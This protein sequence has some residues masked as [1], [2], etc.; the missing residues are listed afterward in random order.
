[1]KTLQTLLF[2]ALC[3][4]AFAVVTCKLDL[5]RD[6]L[7]AEEKQI[8]VVKVSL[9]AEEP[10]DITERAP[11]NLCIVLDRSGSMSGSKLERAKKA[12]VAALRRLNRN[13]RFSLV[14]YDHGVETIVP[15]RSAAD[16]EWIEARIRSI[17]AGGNTAL[18]AGVSQGAAEIRKQLDDKRFTHRILLLSD[19]LANVGPSSPADLG[20]LGKALF[21]EQITVS[22]I[23]LG[24]GYN[25]D[26][27]AELAGKSD[28][29]MYFVESSDD[30]ANIFD[31]ELGDVLRVT[32]RKVT[33]EITIPEGMRPL[34][35]VGRDARI[36]NNKVELEF[37]QLYGGQ[38]K[39]ALMEIE[40]TGGKDGSAALLASAECKY[41]SALT[42]KR[43]QAAGK[44]TA[45][46]S[47]SK[48]EIVKSVDQ[49]VQA[50]YNL[51]KVA[52]LQEK[53]LEL[54][55]EGR[56]EEAVQ[57]LKEESSRLKNDADEYS[58]SMLGVQSERLEEVADKLENEGMS[59][60]LRKSTKNEAYEIK[61]QQSTGSWQETYKLKK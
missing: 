51:N 60:R 55:D 56:E 26:L 1:M 42:Q 40:L 14:I 39:Y 18:F 21:K 32:A 53:V 33:L 24:T 61:Q 43:E 3:T 57:K 23:G 6:V 44:V 54:A 10:A 27:M 2:C 25:E 4:Q 34:R 50:E 5:E 28:G 12:A 36:R 15:A 19:G 20:R 35:V 48:D 11:V 38:E 16:S 29:N 7:K 41:E 22:T 37:N 17:R 47:R 30:L 8:A 58:N 52:E 46:F 31:A 49:R 9:E 45:R 59:K 13:D